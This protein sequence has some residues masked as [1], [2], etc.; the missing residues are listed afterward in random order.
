MTR[1][2]TKTEAADYIRKS[3]SFVDKR[4]KE[5][6]FQQ[7]VHYFKPNGGSVLFD[8]H[9]LDRWVMNDDLREKREIVRTVLQRVTAS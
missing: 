9:E 8:K 3:V 2:L 6:S 4:M 7:G 5:S 1:W